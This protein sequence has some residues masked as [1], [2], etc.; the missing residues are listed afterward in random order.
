MGRFISNKKA[1]IAAIRGGFETIL[2]NNGAQLL[3]VS[4]QTIANNQYSEG[5]ALGAGAREMDLVASG[6][7]ATAKFNDYDGAVSR[8][9]TGRADRFAERAVVT[10]GSHEIRVKVAYALDRAALMHNGYYDASEH[11]YIFGVEF[12]YLASEKQWPSIRRDVAAM[13]RGLQTLHVKIPSAE[14]RAQKALERMERVAARQ[15]AANMND[16]GYDNNPLGVSANLWENFLESPEGRYVDSDSRTGK[17][18]AQDFSDFPT[19]RVLVEVRGYR[20]FKGVPRWGHWKQWESK[21]QRAERLDSI[22]ARLQTQFER[23]YDNSDSG[24]GY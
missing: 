4:N 19:S 2:P 23:Y 16:W 14:E 7:I 8:A 9:G 12:L 1:V 20:K 22:I 11:K 24:D 10:Q 18:A 17:S 21:D 15:D 3:G 13:L 6:Y 5:K